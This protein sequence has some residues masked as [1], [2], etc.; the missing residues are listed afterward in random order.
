MYVQLIQALISTFGWDRER[1][2]SCTFLS[3]MLCPLSYIFNIGP[4]ASESGTIRGALLKLKTC[5]LPLLLSYRWELR[6]SGRYDSDV[7]DEQDCGD[8]D[9]CLASLLNEVSRVG[10]HVGNIC[11]DCASSRDCHNSP[12][13]FVDLHSLTGQLG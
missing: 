13:L 8:I 5:E 6:L 12:T 1:F 10:R 7:V 3:K 4:D 9:S 11:I 2:D